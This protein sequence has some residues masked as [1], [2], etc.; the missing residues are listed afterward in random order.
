MYWRVSGKG[1]PETTETTEQLNGV[2]E[3]ADGGIWNTI[4][5]QPTDDSEMVMSFILVLVDQGR[6]DPEEAGKAYIFW[7]GCDRIYSRS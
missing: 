7:L 2:R 1:F 6:Y 5:G 4:A 3:L